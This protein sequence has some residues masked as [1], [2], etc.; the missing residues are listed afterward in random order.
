MRSL[1]IL[2]TL[3]AAA[4][5]AHAQ[6]SGAPSPVGQAITP[7][8]ASAAERAVESRHQK[9]V[10]RSKARAARRAARAASAQDE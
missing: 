3:L 7:Q 2:V 8:A 5:I 9:A 4:W 1:A 6:G 10:V